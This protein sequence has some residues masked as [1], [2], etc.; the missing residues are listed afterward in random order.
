MRNIH[1][2]FLVLISIILIPNSSMACGM[3][4]NK[5]TCKTE[6]SSGNCKMKCCEKKS[7]DKSEKGCEGKCGK[8]T[9]QI[10][11]ISYGATLPNFTEIKNNYYFVLTSRHSFFNQETAISDGFYFIWSPPNIG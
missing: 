11:S 7:K 2:L 5:S 6:M 9:C 8:S 4:N 3:K 1:I 10:Q